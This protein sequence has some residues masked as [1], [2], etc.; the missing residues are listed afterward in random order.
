MCTPLIRLKDVKLAEC[1]GVPSHVLTLKH[2]V[3]QQYITRK[4]LFVCFI[5]QLKE[6]SAGHIS[7]LNL[8]SSVS[9]QEDTT[10]HLVSFTSFKMS[11]YDV[12]LS[13]HAPIHFQLFSASS[14]ISNKLHLS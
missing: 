7:M 1:L 14:Y 5:K 4:Q 11:I 9:T 13:T 12:F 10:K 6:P 2:K 3:E 8:T